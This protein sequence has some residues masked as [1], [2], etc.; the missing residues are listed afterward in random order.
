MLTCRLNF[1]AMRLTDLY[2]ILTVE[3][4]KALAARAGTDAGYLWQLACRWRGKR[5]SVSLMSRLV[6]ADDR[7]TLVDLAQEFSEDRPNA[8]TT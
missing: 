4:R 7:L 2:P 3:E 1:D 5:A 8:Q 6:A